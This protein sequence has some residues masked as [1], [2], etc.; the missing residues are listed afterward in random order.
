MQDVSN[1]IRLMELRAKRFIKPQDS[2]HR[3]WVQV[4]DISVYIQSPACTMIFRARH[5]GP[6][7]LRLPTSV[8]LES[9][10]TWESEATDVQL[11]DT[12]FAQCTN[13]SPETTL[14]KSRSPLRTTPN[15]FCLKPCLEK[16]DP[17]G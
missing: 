15:W 3:M 1:R 7:W 8:T 5:H 14:V 4:L 6:I 10:K 17:R 2:I 11:A 16:L 9:T 12:P 13:Q